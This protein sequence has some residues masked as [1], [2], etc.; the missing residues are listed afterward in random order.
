[1]RSFNSHPMWIRV[2]SVWIA[3]FGPYVIVRMMNAGH[4]PQLKAFFEPK[5]GSFPNGNRNLQRTVEQ[6]SLCVAKRKAHK[7]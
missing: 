2:F 5:I 1:M 6:I 4:L 3:V 7:L